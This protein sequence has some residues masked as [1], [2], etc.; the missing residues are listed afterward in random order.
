[1]FFNMVYYN[2]ALYAIGVWATE[3]N[4]WLFPLSQWNLTPTLFALGFLNIFGLGLY[5]VFKM[6]GNGFT[7]LMNLL[8]VIFSCYAVM[9]LG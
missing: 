8:I 1:M 9:V 5:V 4:V 6:L 2:L 7:S 3:N